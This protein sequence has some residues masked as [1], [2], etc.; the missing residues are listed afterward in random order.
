MIM[1]VGYLGL[2]ISFVIITTIFLII[3]FKANVSNWIKLILVP[4]ALWYGLLLYSIPNNFAGWAIDSEPLDKTIILNIWV[5]E[6]SIKNK[7]GIYFW[8]LV[9]PSIDELVKF[10]MDPSKFTTYIN[11]SSP[12]SYRIPY[13][14][15]FHKKWLEAQKQQREKGGILLY[16][17]GMKPGSGTKGGKQKEGFEDNSGFRLINPEDLLPKV[18]PM[19][20]V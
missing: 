8:G 16:K 17:K 1:G 20:G 3:F 18:Q 5:E 12:R 15:E 19:P 10:N 14:E 7:G 4:V 9:Y 11:T 13:D 2:S 6:P